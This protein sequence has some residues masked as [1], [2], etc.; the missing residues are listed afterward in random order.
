MVTSEGVLS[1]HDELKS[2]LVLLREE[3]DLSAEQSKQY[4][5]HAPQVALVVIALAFDDLGRHVVNG[6]EAVLVKLARVEKNGRAKVNDFDFEL[7]RG[8][9]V[10]QDVLWLQVAVDYIPLVA[11]CY[12]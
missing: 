7:L 6:A 11:V 1:C 3:R 9:V 10:Y 2:L 12:R 8:R 4:D 5:S